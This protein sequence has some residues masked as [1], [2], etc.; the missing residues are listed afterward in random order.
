MQWGLI[1]RAVLYHSIFWCSFVRLFFLK[2]TKHLLPLVS[3]CWHSRVILLQ[4]LFYLKKKVCGTAVREKIRRSE[5]P[6][7]LLPRLSAG[8]DKTSKH[9]DHSPKKEKKRKEW[10]EANFGVS[11][12]SVS[13][14]GPSWSM[15]KSQ[16]DVRVPSEIANR[17]FNRSH[18]FG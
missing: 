5:I 1:I 6:N 10:N 7:G 14:R 8:G 18:A 12:Q 3:F 9:L 4:Q 16:S 17:F 11:F 2:D 15:I 13:L